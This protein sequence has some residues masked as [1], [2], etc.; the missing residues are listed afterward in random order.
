METVT[1]E[2][3]EW[4]R[5]EGVTREDVYHWWK[6]EKKRVIHFYG[7]DG[8]REV[9]KTKWVPVYYE[10]VRNRKA[11]VV[12]TNALPYHSSFDLPT[13]YRWKTVEIE[14]EVNY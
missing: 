7:G 3:D 11:L 8:W 1:I 2:H 5:V 4:G 9:P 13:G 12:V 10:I 14:K 6:N